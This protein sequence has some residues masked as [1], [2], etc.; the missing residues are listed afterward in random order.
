[1]IRSCVELVDPTTQE[2]RTVYSENM[3]NKT[4]EGS[5]ILMACGSDNSDC[6]VTLNDSGQGLDQSPITKLIIYDEDYKINEVFSIDSVHDYIM[7]S[8]VNQLRVEND[9][10]FMSNYSNR[11]ILGRIE[12][13]EIIPI[14][15]QQ[16]LEIAGKSDYLV[17]FTRGTNLILLLD[18]DTGV[19]NQISIPLDD[20]Y[21]I[22]CVLS[23]N[24]KVLV[25]LKKDGDVD[26]VFLT[27]LEELIRQDTVIE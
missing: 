6:L 8:R 4:L 15:Q 22:K 13:G 5:I 20:D 23:D 10:V 18:L 14:L 9:Y 3:N 12:N 21:S 2:I 25:V 11:S 27:D 17:L 7:S 26:R 19:V 24:N 1:M 16:E